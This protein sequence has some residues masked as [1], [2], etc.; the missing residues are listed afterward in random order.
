MVRIVLATRV[1]QKQLPQHVSARGQLT[2]LSGMYM[3]RSEQKSIKN[4]HLGRS[5]RFAADAGPSN[6]AGPM[7]PQ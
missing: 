4:C 5:D 1:M 3:G 7:N 2:A 6:F